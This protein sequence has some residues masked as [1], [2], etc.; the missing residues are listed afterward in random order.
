MTTT[1]LSARMSAAALSAKRMSSV[2]TTE[3]EL[4]EAGQAAI[5]TALERGHDLDA[6]TT[7]ELAILLRD[8][9]RRAARAE[10]KERRA[11]R[12]VDAALRTPGARRYSERPIS[13]HAADGLSD[14]DACIFASRIC[15]GA[16]IATD[17]RSVERARAVMAATAGTVTTVL[18]R[19][20]IGRHYP[21]T[22]S[23][24]AAERLGLTAPD[25]TDAPS[26]AIPIVEYAPSGP[27][28]SR[29]VPVERG[30]GGATLGLHVE[31]PRIRHTESGAGESEYSILRAH[32]ADTLGRGEYADALTRS[33]HAAAPIRRGSRGRAVAQSAVAA[34]DSLA[35]GMSVVR[36]PNALTSSVAI[37]STSR[38]TIRAVS[39]VDII[40]ASGWTIDRVGHVESRP[41]WGVLA[42]LL[43]RDRDTIAEHVKTWAR[44][45]EAE[46]WSSSAVHVAPFTR[47][48]RE[49]RELWSLVSAAIT[50]QTIHVV[51]PPL[52]R[53]NVWRYDAASGTNVQ[54]QVRTAFIP[55]ADLHSA[56]RAYSGPHAPAVARE[57][58]LTLR[59]RAQGLSAEGPSALYGGA[60]IL[61]D[62]QRATDPIGAESDAG[63][64]RVPRARLAYV[65]AVTAP[66]RPMAGPAPQVAPETDT[67]PTYR[68]AAPVG[69]SPIPPRIGTP[70]PTAPPT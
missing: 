29:A 14:S 27:R 36:D 26:G 9:L 3:E 48:A 45:C 24:A 32:G 31:G 10:E 8:E 65:R 17:T 69:P 6:L 50:P 35:R 60:P 54:R 41:Q 33:M 49:V 16:F 42:D 44:R 43:R 40:A 58:R 19:R 22:T 18:T 38:T 23:L 53:M 47:D 21:A 62:R 56:G 39:A 67:A 37:A 64:A 13:A 2:P 51:G 68:P 70:T 61:W 28:L 30:S 34:L 5:A 66:R 25:M 12:S 57:P 59:R 46:A 63:G 1:D 15:S 11:A 55:I 7:R 20:P 52:T 4:L